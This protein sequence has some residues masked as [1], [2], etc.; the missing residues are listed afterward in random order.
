MA[1]IEISPGVVWGASRRVFFYVVARL[2][3]NTS[4]T[5]LN[6]RFADV[7]EGYTD[8][9]ISDLDESEREQIRKVVSSLVKDVKDAGPTM[10]DEPE[11]F[12]GFLA[13]LEELEQMIS[14]NPT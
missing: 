14:N 11:F 1:V 6:Q 10:L 4:I 8:L 13:R 5:R 2:Q 7:E 12:P 3:E 9:D